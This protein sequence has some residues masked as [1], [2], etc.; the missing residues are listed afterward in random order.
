M[1][2]GSSRGVS[3]LQ[4]VAAVERGYG[5]VRVGPGGDVGPSVE[6]LGGT[7]AVAEAV[8]DGGA[9]DHSPAAE[10]GHLRK[11]QKKGNTVR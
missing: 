6:E 10:T 9:E 4:H 7:D 11:G 1:F 2:E 8:I 5:R 3:R